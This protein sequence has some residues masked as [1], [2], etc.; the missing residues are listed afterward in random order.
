MAFKITI[1][2]PKTR[3]AWQLER[4]SPVL[5][6]MQVG[7]RFEGS[8]IGL[9]GYTLEITGGSDKEGFPLRRDLPGTG[10]RKIL[11][12]KGVGYNPK[13]KGIKRRKTVRG[14]TISE[15]IAQINTKVVEKEED[16]EEIPKALG[17]KEGKTEEKEGEKE[18]SE[19]EEK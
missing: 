13:E 9:N 2:D 3:K 8:I 10:R 4:D 18:K 16:V 6:G 11:L 14:N 12:A 7:E 17:L 5:I 1:S 15:E 19:E